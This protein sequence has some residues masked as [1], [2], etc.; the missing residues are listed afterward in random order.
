M[1]WF[2]YCQRHDTSTGNGTAVPALFT[3]NLFD[4]YDVYDVGSL[5]LIISV[6]CKE[7][8]EIWWIGV[9]AT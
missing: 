8:G 9:T 3:F 4:V 6:Q 2:W 1:Y 5:V 7:E